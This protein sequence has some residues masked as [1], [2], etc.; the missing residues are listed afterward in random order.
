MDDWFQMEAKCRDYIGRLCWPDGFVCERCTATGEP[1][2]A[3]RGVFRCKVCKA[4]TSLKASGVFQDTCKSLRL[5]FLAMWF[6]TSQKNGLS[7]LGLQGVLGL[8]GYATAWTR[9]RD[10]EL[11]L[12]FW[13]ERQVTFPP[14]SGDDPRTS[15]EIMTKRPRRNHTPVFKA[16]VAMAVPKGEK[17]LTELARHFAVHASQITQ[18]K[19]Q[20]LEGAA[21]VFGH[22]GGEA[23]APAIDF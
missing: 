21:G 14:D 10:G 22:G 3:A 23:S 12:G 15:G 17:T 2:V 11:A 20:L 4:S 13:K 1:W 18:W 5:W 16:N 19:A 8:G 7:V 6:N 9:L